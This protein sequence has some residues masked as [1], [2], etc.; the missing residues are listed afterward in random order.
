ML[1]VILH[2]TA[3]VG[4]FDEETHNAAFVSEFRFVPNQ[5]E[6]FELDVLGTFRNNK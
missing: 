2:F 3:E 5:N 1:I 4:D 6:E